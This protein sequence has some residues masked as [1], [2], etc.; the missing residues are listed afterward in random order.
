MNNSVRVIT[1]CEEWCGFPDLG[2]PAVTARVDSGARTSALH[3]LNI[4]PFTRNE[5]RWVSFEV[6]PLQN[7]RSTVLRC[8]AKVHD[9]RVVKNSGGFAE[10]RTVIKT[11]FAIGKHQWEIE[12][13]LANRDSM[14]Y[15]MLLGREAMSGRLLVDPSAGFCLETA[16]PQK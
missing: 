13:T 5:S 15:R 14:G 11:I 10:K 6:H 8:E 3:A 9:R 12:L 7:D 1:G 4:Q 2:I 16:P